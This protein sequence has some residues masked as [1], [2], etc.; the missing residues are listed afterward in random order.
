MNTRIIII[1]VIAVFQTVVHEEDT[2][3]LTEPIVAPIKRRK[4]AVAEQDLPNTTY[5]M[6]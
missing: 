5:N 4:F 2:Q 1:M 6:E 3:A